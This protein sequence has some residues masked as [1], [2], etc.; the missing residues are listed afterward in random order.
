M[1]RI[2]IIIALIVSFITTASAQYMPHVRIPT[3]EEAKIIKTTNSW[4]TAAIAS[5]ITA[6][7]FSMMAGIYQIERTEAEFAS[8]YNTDKVIVYTACLL[9]G[10]SAFVA[11]ISWGEYTKFKHRL[12]NNKL[13]LKASPRGLIIEF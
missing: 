9:A 11:T 13:L 3:P 6:A 5:S 12:P 10:T 8:K 2:I 7:G 1:K 4:H